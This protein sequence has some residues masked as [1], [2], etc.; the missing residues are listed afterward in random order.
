LMG[1]LTVAIV[2]KINGATLATPGYF[3]SWIG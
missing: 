2:G 1:A 3:R